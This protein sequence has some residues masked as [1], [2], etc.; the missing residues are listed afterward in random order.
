MHALVARVLARTSDDWTMV[1]TL[2]LVH[3]DECLVRHIAAS[4]YAFFFPPLFCSLIIL[5]SSDMIQRRNLRTSNLKLLILD[6]ADEMLSQGF[7][8][9]I[10]DI[11]R[12]LPNNTQVL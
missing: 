3:L 10:Y 6:E 9:Q 7:K 8:E 12:Y 2:F 5:V 11:Y 1:A 4:V